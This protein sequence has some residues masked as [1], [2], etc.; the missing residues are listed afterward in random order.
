MRY[1]LATS[2]FS[3]NNDLDIISSSSDKAKYLLGTLP[4]SLYCKKKKKLYMTYPA[5]R[6]PTFEI[7]VLEFSIFF[8]SVDS[9]NAS[10]MKIMWLDLINMVPILA[11]LFCRDIMKES[12]LSPW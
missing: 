5:S 9:V 3:I 12:V 1:S 8:K 11:K 10:G 2:V 7:L 4:P 6:S